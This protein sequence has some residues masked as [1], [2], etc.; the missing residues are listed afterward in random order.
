MST[1]P[2]IAPASRTATRRGWLAHGLCAALL[3]SAPVGGAAAQNLVP[4]PS[5]EKADPTDSTRP[6][7]WETD[8]WG[9]VKATFTYQNTGYDGSRSLR[10]DVT[11][12]G[13]QGDAKWWS[14]AFSVTAGGGAY[15]VSD[16]YR[17]SV[18][19][20]LMVRAISNSGSGN[21]SWITVKNLDPAAS[22]TRAS[23]S[24]SLPSWTE[25]VRVLHFIQARGW[26]ETDS[27]EMRAAGSS[28]QGVVS[29]VFDDG[30]VSAYN[31]ALPVM[32]T[33]ALRGTFFIVADYVD[34]PGYQADYMVSSQLKQLAASGH[35]IASHC[36]DHVDLRTLSAAAVSSQLSRSRTKLEGYGL[37]VVGF[38]PPFGATNAAI[39]GQIQQQ[40]GYSR[41][42]TAGI[43]TPPYDRYNLR[44]DIVADT[45]T[46][47]AF[48]GL[49][50]SAQAQNG[51]L[52]LLYHRFS[53]QPSG[54]TYVSP[55][56]FKQQ[57]DY[58][59]S[60]KVKVLPVGEVLGLWKPS[61]IVTGDGG[62]TDGGKSF[63]RPPPV[64]RGDW[65]TPGGCAV[66]AASDPGAAGPGAALLLLLLLGICRTRRRLRPLR[67][68]ARIR[69][70]TEVV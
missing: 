70:P 53:S 5:V 31:Q 10:L 22:W 39:T 7:S 67:A 2:V 56:N 49:V 50:Q 41:G 15:T 13:S 47:S 36:W 33:R 18:K 28:G 42:L 63:A 30:W 69:L 52:I 3:V 35:E 37:K 1:T 57:M 21:S 12:S 17:S 34:K 64:P 32:G 4:N 29:V 61:S 65:G 8:T 55:A 68:L 59:V 46:L 6:Q 9:D 58:L 27:Y 45:T 38:A 54:S 44:T 24:I 40:Y 16:T 19:S 14:R 26:L 60:A 20:T 48:Q 25:Q 23:G 62:V 43:N 66:A 51:W 11:A